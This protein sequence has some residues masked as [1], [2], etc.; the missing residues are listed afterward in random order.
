[1]LRV[2]FIGLSLIILNSIAIANM[3]LGV[4]VSNAQETTSTIG[5]SPIKAK[6]NLKNN[7]KFKKDDHRYNKHYRDFDYNRNGYYNNDGLYFGFF[8]RRGYF[9]NNIYFEY[10][11]QYT[12][13]DRRDRRGYFEPYRHHYRRY[14]YYRDNDWNRIHHYREPDEIV[15]GHYYEERY[16]PRDRRDGYVR[17]RYISEERVPNRRDYQDYYREEPYYRDN[18]REFFHNDFFDNQP[19]DRYI[20]NRYID[21]RYRDNRYRDNRYRKTRNNGHIIYHRFS[22]KKDKHK[23]KKKNKDYI[24]KINKSSNSHRK[25]QI[26]K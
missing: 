15:Y 3:S 23:D 25:V 22:D 11:S 18:N 26:I 16:I 24:R 12:Y 10:N 4:S 8:D 20:D 13:N 19:R 14:R 1:M 6:K 5:N 2:I 21:N 9:F 17:E 7:K